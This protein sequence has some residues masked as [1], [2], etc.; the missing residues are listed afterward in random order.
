MNRRNILSCLFPAAGIF[1]LILDGKCAVAAAREAV[2]LCVRTLIPSLFPYLVL[3]ALLTA[4]LTNRSGFLKPLGKL[5]GIPSGAE[6]LLAV[7]FL[8]GYPAGAANTAL[9]WKQGRISREDARRLLP[10]CNNAGPAFLFGILGSLFSDFRICFVLW[11][12]LILSALLTGSVTADRPPAAP[13]GIARPITFPE[14]LER[15]VRVM[16]LIC[17]WVVLFRIVTGFLDRWFLWL[18]PSEAQVLIT[19]LLELTWGC[20]ALEAVEQEGLR[21][22]LSALF[23]SFGGLCVTMQTASAASGLSMKQYLPAKL[24]QSGFCFLACTALQVLFPAEHRWHCPVPLLVFGVLITGLLA[25]SLKR[26][27]KISSIPAFVGV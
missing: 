27:K 24:L 23:L 14:A 15:S 19:G 3:S 2:E 7:G 4:G 16:G 10:I 25:L 18:L 21:F 8:G 1:L 20:I 11:G 22:V 6:G 12:I 13:P 26:N 9:A 5:T 17:G